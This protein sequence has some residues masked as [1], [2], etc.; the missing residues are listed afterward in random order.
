MSS[1]DRDRN[2]NN[3]SLRATPEIRVKL[4]AAADRNGRSL[5]AE[6]TI[7]LEKSLRDDD[8]MAALER[9]ELALGISSIAPEDRFS[10]IVS[11]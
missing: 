9:I 2:L 5:S 6:I 4:I 10:G 7:R 3:L 1:L 11:K 8:V